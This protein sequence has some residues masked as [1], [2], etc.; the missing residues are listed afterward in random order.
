MVT[1]INLTLKEH[2]FFLL[3]FLMCLNIFSSDQLDLP[4]EDKPQ[5]TNCVI[6]VIPQANNVLF[7]F[8]LI[9]HNINMNHKIYANNLIFLF[10][11]LEP[12][13]QIQNTITRQKRDHERNCFTF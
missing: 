5:N 4:P 13:K 7:A 9:F 12:K 8:K 10:H 2:L 3:T 6:L 11:Y 1:Q